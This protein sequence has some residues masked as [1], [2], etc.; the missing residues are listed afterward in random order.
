[1]EKTATSV[2]DIW[3]IPWVIHLGIAQ[4]CDRTV[5]LPATDHRKEEKTTL[6][7]TT[8]RTMNLSLTSV[9]QTLAG[10]VRDAGVRGV[11]FDYDHLQSEVT[12]RFKVACAMAYAKKGAYTV[13]INRVG[14]C[15]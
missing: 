2:V 3:E 1:M 6:V 13:H 5:E 11:G 15:Y 7:V 10:N 8:Y 14:V 12:C 4:W 9:S